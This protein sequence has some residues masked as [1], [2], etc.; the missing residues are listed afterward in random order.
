MQ[1]LFSQLQNY[2]DIACRNLP[3]RDARGF[4][5]NAIGWRDN[6]VLHLHSL[7]HRE[8][9]TFDHRLILCHLNS[10]QQTVHRSYDRTSGSSIDT[11][12]GHSSIIRKGH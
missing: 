2:N 6:L 12:W 8:T 7:Q 4:K 5:N 1:S 11:F 9:L 3:L 10:K